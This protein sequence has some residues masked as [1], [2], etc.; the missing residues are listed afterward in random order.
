MFSWLG[1]SGL[2]AVWTAAPVGDLGLVDLEALVVGRGET[3]RG[4]DR[5]VDVHHA[6][7]VAADQMVMVVAYAIL[8]ARRRAGRLDT[9]DETLGDQQAE[10]V[11]HRLQ[12]DGADLGANGLG[13]AVGGDVRLPRH[14][15]Q[16]GEPLSSYLDAA[17]T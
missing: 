4:T 10:R 3:R 15:P 2:P 8:V 17:F 12:G 1:R 14:G 13:H 7:A 6:A 5:A 9:A 16:H 11:V